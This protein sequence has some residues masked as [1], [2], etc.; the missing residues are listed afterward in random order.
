MKAFAIRVLLGVALVLQFVPAWPA[1]TIKLAFLGGLTGPYALQDEEILKNVRAAADLVNTR[2]GV[3]GGRMFEIVP[4]DHKANPQDALIVLKQAIDQ[5]IR[6]VISGRSNVAHAITDALN[7]HNARD[8]GR[9]VLFLNLTGIDPALTETKCSFW[10]FRFA[11]HSDTMVSALADYMAGRLSVKTVYLL[12]QDYAYGQA[13][14]RAAREMLPRRR[15][16]IRIVGDDLVPL[17]K[18]KDFAPYVAKIRA[19]GA[20]SVLTGNWGS[21]LTLLVKASADA[22]LKATYYTLAAATPGNMAA[23]GTAGV[24]RVTTLASWS[25]NVADPAWEKTLIGYKAHYQALSNLDSLIAFRVMEMLAMAIGAAGSVD[26]VKVAF[27]LEGLR[28]AGPSGDSWMRAEDHQI[29]APIY[30]LRFVKAG[31]QGVKH[32]EEGSGYGWKMEALI[33]AK[34]AVPPL[35]CQMERPPR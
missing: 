20:D 14:A 3:A 4:L 2:I 33:P 32:D 8:P 26:P 6:F 10:H 1:D 19:S 22:G 11:A 23:S 16:D 13:V 9:S 15:P 12:N 17:G 28:Y 18:V 31:Q 29:I 5:D 35:N 30:V 27:A 34:D 24:D 7:K 25:I 21:D